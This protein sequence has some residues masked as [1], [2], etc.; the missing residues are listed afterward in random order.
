M[1]YK[2]SL[3]TGSLHLRFWIII[4]FEDLRLFLKSVWSIWCSP[5]NLLVSSRDL[6]CSAS[7]A[8]F[9]RIHFLRGD[10]L[11]GS[12]SFVLDRCYYSTS[13]T[14]FEETV[15]GVWHSVLW[16]WTSRNLRSY[17]FPSSS[18]PINTILPA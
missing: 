11:W 9:V 1:F 12:T 4:K 7:L 16:C 17:F 15:G 3:V 14:V 6:G 18:T 10:S 5:S 8:V 2:F 13:V